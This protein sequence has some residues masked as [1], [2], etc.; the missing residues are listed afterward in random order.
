MMKMKLAKTV[1]HQ[2]KIVFI[3]RGYFRTP[4]PVKFGLNV[5]CVVIGH[6]ALARESKKRT[7]SN[8]VMTCVTILS[9][10][11]WH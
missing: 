8:T 11:D 10:R 9:K 6:R 7:V 1:N 2:R 5:V 4:K 3:A